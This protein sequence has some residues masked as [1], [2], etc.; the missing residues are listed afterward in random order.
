VRW[1]SEMA[2]RHDGFHEITTAYRQRE[3]LLIYVWRCDRCGARLGEAGREAY[4]PRYDPLG[5]ERF[6]AAGSATR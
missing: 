6:L 3:G 2:C 4:R 5:N 1:S